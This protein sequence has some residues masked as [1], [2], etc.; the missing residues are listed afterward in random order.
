MFVAAAG[1][2]PIS[3]QSFG[4]KLYA[5][6]LTHNF[7][8]SFSNLKQIFEVHDPASKSIDWYGN[9][10]HVLHQN[11][12]YSVQNT[13][14]AAVKKVKHNCSLCHSVACPC[15]TPNSSV[16]WVDLFVVHRQGFT[17]VRVTGAEQEDRGINRRHRSLFE[18]A[19]G[20]LATVC[21]Q[22][23][24]IPIPGSCKQFQAFLSSFQTVP[25]AF[26]MCNLIGIFCRVLLFEVRDAP[27]FGA[28]KLLVFVFYHEGSIKL[29]TL[30]VF[31]LV[32]VQVIL[33]SV[34]HIH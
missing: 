34:G 12:F 27:S 4:K 7:L 13:A 23:L 17:E 3:Q 16:F 26:I 2:Q 30:Q 9:P 6:Y 29:W 18:V 33:S 21:L 1:Q 15:L 14:H 8:L 32:I 25:E 22:V 24:D 19:Q 10:P 28:C 11:I 5:H 20:S 31:V